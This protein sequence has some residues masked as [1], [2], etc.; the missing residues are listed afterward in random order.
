MTKEILLLKLKA[1]KDIVF[2]MIKIRII[3]NI[4]D[5]NICIIK[6]LENPLNPNILFEDYDLDRDHSYDLGRYEYIEYLI[7][8]FN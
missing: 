5:D 2:D 3:K 8:L 4:N 1:D 6:Y 7:K